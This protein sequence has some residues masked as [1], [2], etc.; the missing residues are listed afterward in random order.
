MQGRYLIACT[1]ASFVST[2]ANAAPP[3]TPAADLQCK[4]RHPIEEVG[5]ITAVPVQIQN[6]ML[7]RID[8]A[9]RE[10]AKFEWRH[11]MA[12]RGGDFNEIGVW[13]AEN[14]NLPWRRFIRAGHLDSEWFVWFEHGGA[15]Y[16]AYSK[17]IALFHIRLGHANPIVRAFVAYQQEDPCALTDDLIDNKPAPPG[18]GGDAW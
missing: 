17:N 10:D 12:P 15:P 8:P 2:T 11:L 16:F 1:V 9:A 18:L 3:P 4:F 7:A 5:D 14:A 13:N 6:A